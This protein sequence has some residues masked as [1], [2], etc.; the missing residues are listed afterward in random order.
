MEGALQRRQVVLGAILADLGFELPVKALDGIRWGLD[1][2]SVRR[3]DMF[4]G[5]SRLIV[6]QGKERRSGPPV[7]FDYS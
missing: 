5:H 2:D 7:A 6:K 4:E 1:G 3:G